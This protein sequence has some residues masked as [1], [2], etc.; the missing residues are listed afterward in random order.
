MARK[1]TEPQDDAIETS[2]N[3]AEAVE[4]AAVPAE[5]ERPA[6]A[7]M[8][9][10]EMIEIP[11]LDPF[12]SNFARVTSSPEEVILDFG[13][14]PQPFGNSTVPIEIQRRLVLNFYTAKRLL[15]ALNMA[16][17]RHEQVF[18][19]LETDITKRIAPQLRGGQ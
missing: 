18:G 6:A 15:A 9:V 4:P 17:H 10:Q 19:I 7:V 5:G 1:K 3:S 13:L 12:Y 8:A 14:N 2:Q 11:R 16:V